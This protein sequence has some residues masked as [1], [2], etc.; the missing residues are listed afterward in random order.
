MKKYWRVYYEWSWIE[1]DAD[2][3]FDDTLQG[4]LRGE[5]W[6]TIKSKIE[7]GIGD[8]ELKRWMVAV[9]EDG[10]EHGDADFDYGYVVDGELAEKTH[11]Y[12]YHVPKR[13]HKE[14][15]EWKQK[16]GHNYEHHKKCS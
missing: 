8:I 7:D 4:L 15:N 12:G 13:F 14:F 10:D 6:D 16:K 5:T 1:Y 2:V 9:D 11:W 3:H